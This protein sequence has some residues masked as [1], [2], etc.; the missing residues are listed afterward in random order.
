MAEEH[1]ESFR[2]TDESTKIEEDAEKQPDVA[3]I[4]SPQTPTITFNEQE[5]LSEQFQNYLRIAEAFMK[6]LKRPKDIEICTNL[7]RKVQRLNDSK[8]IEVKRNNNAF[9]RY[10]L[11]VLKWT[12]D[13]QPLELY[14][15]WYRNKE[16]VEGPSESR[17]WLEDNKSYMALK[18]LKDGTN[19]IYAAVCDE[20]SAG[21]QDGGLNILA[22]RGACSRN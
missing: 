4:Q 10:C 2:S 18:S 19:I 9:F 5:I 22:K 1:E 20:P 3:K 15:Q 11:K 13:N 14:Q 12:S 16:L 6:T 17:T 8:H 7:L 21:W